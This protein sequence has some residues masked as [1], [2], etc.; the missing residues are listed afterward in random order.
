M[1]GHGRNTRVGNH[2]APRGWNP[3][4][5]PRCYGH[6]QGPPA[7][8]FYCLA[9][10]EALIC[11][12]GR[13][14]AWP[15][16]AYRRRPAD[17]GKRRRATLV[18]ILL[19][20]GNGHVRMADVELLVEVREFAPGILEEEAAADGERS[21]EQ[22]HKERSEEDENSGSVGV[23]Q[24]RLVPGHELQ[25]VEEPKSVAQQDDD[26]D[27]QCVGD[28]REVL[29]SGESSGKGFSTNL[30]RFWERAESG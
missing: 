17:R 5:E 22:V 19:V 9:C 4:P 21:T 3:A 16:R 20:H 6:G 28:H 2:S 12:G 14:G 27:Q 26:G 11:A 13:S 10:R 8:D 23:V 15:C 1:R 24:D 18:E 7:Q 29:S 30:L 25:L